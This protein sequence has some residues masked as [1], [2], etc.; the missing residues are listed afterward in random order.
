MVEPNRRL[1]TLEPVEIK[2]Q[3]PNA[4]RVDMGRN[5]A[6]WFEIRMKGTPGKKITFQF[7]ERPEQAETYGQR[8]EFILGSGGEGV[9][10]H[11]FN[12]SAFRW[13]TIDGLETAPRKE[14]IRGYLITTDTAR[15][16]RFECSDAYLNRLY[17]TTFWTFR[18]L[19]LGG[20]TVDCPHRERFGYGGDAHATMETAL[21]NFGM[22]A[23]Y[24]KWL[25]DWR[26]LQR[27]DGDIPYTAPTYFGGGG[28]AWSGVCV[29]LPWQVYLHYG[30]RRILQESYPAMQRWIAFLQTKSKNHLLEKWGGI[31]DFLGDWVPPGK[32]QNPEERVDE[33]ST[34]FFNNCYYLDNM[35]T[36][37]KVAELLG[38]NQEADAY[39]QEAKEIA[40]ALQREFF[41][42][43]DHSYA[44]GD[45][46]YE[47]MPLLM[48]VTPE[49]LQPDVMKRL[50][51]EILVNKKG[52]IDTGTHGT[53]YLIKL[54]VERNRND[55][56]FQ[57]ANQRTYPGWGYMLDRGATTLWEQWD[58]QNSLLHS[59]FVSIGSW[60]LDGIAGIRLD[61][62][63]PGYKHFMIRP[64]IVGNL[65]WAKG[66]YDSPYGT[67]RSEW[68]L[69]DGRLILNI[70]VPPNT[71]A[72]V[73]VPTDNPASV[74]ESGQLASQAPSVH[75]VSTADRAAVYEVKSG[76]YRF[77]A[78]WSS[79]KSEDGKSP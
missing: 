13:V 49:A 6:G 71:T 25:V 22:G 7:A 68:R 9:F 19:S 4:F 10:C 45:Q 64:G 29:T 46:L 23:F 76:H 79:P 3:G 53:Y 62:A 52:H 36:V 54:L 69:S 37:T 21:M 70:D 44:N 31:W 28:P 33:H 18:S 1:E 56:I 27:P 60:F 75:F 11:R 57:M 59:T 74:T 78:P 30:D 55:L 38:K 35:A 51:Q 24:T 2:P 48:G 41:K 47:A 63:Q 72:T 67:I 17:E 43:D 73:V 20:Y 65:A 14:D 58:G 50:E 5:Y 32:G 26:D 15:S 8:S 12:Y 34:L 42:P 61:P 40:L 77:S 66:E 39:R 16:S